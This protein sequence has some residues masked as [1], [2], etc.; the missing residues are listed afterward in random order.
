MVLLEQSWNE[1]V[2]VNLGSPFDWCNL[3]QMVAC[4]RFDMFTL[5]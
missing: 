4:E 3:K 1:M 2:L 5:D